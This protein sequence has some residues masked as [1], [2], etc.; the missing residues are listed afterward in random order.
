VA[1]SQ[2]PRRPSRETVEFVA[3]KKQLKKRSQTIT[4]TLFAMDI[5]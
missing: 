2:K 4:N 5:R 3:T 1:I